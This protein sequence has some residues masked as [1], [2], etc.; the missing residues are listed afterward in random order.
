MPKTF[1]QLE[2]EALA[3]KK[4][5]SGNLAIAVQQGTNGDAYHMYPFFSGLGGYIFGIEQG[6]QPRPVGHRRGEQDVPQERVADRQVEQGRPDQLEG[7][8]LD[9][10]ERVP[11]GAG[12]VLDHGPVELATRSRRAA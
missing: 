1:K 8:Q 10:A 9:R 11:E 2:T 4:K 7:R 3:F 6:R 5:K 12:R